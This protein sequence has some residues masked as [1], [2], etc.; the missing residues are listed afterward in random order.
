MADKKYVFQGALRW[1]S[2]ELVAGKKDDSEIY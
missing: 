1:K 2:V